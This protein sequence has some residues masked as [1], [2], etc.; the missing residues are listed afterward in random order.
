M[1]KED[2][3]HLFTLEENFWWFAGM[4]EVTGALLDPV[5]PP[6][7][8]RKV[9]DAGCGTGGNLEWLQR[10][11]GNG[12]VFGIDFSS[13]ALQFSQSREPKHLAGASVTALPFDDARFDLVTS[14]DVL[15]QLPAKTD[16]L[17]L[18]EMFRVL[19]PGGVLFV[20]VAAYEWLRSGHDEALQ[21]QH[22]Y[23]LSELSSRIQRVGFRILR[24]TY[25]NSLL[26]PAVAFR[27]LVLK[28]TGLADNGSDVKPLPPG[29]EWLNPLL[30]GILR[31]EA[32]YVRQSLFRLP[33]GLSA[34]CIAEKPRTS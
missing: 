1:L 4:R 32:W 3:E 30:K 14:Y 34:I 27:R 16:E 21:T 17:A 11:A 33:A 19:R 10:Y 12:K 28:P 26:L 15:G 20:R 13:D 5:C 2:F 18:S 31:A 25:A 9:L 8:A 22:R 29:L 24:T 7:R 6:G 23:R